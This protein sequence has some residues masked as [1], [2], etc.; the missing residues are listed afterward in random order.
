VEAKK[1]VSRLFMGSSWHVE[2]RIPPVKAVMRPFPY[3]VRADDLVDHARALMTEH[4]IRHLPVRDAG[5]LVGIVSDR[6]LR[7]VPAG[8]PVR[9]VMSVPVHRVD[10]ER[11][12]DEV[13]LMLAEGE[14]G[15]VV[16]TREGRVAGIFTT[17]DACRLLGE[18]L[19]RLAPPE[20]GGDDAA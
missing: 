15:S 20:A 8:A 11:P 1:T 17:T 7:G 16:V 6:D 18:T 10:M 5:E 4:E 9:S 19:H 13:V 14:I 3:S 2:G 12:L